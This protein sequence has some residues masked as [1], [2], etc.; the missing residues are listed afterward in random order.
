VVQSIEKNMRTWEMKRFFAYII[1][2]L[3]FSAGAVFAGEQ[4]G[5]EAQTFPPQSTNDPNAQGD[6]PGP[7]SKNSTDTTSGSKEAGPLYRHDESANSVKSR[8]QIDMG[9]YVGVDVERRQ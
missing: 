8:W 1:V 3:L 7:G 5:Y 2:M 9:G 6:R 4:G